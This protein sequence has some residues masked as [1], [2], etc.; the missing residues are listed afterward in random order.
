MKLFLQVFLFA[1]LGSLYTNVLEGKVILFDERVDVQQKTEIQYDVPDGCVV[2]GLGFRAHVDNITTMY[3][4]YHRLMP[5]GTLAQAKEIKL[6]SE[7]E[8]ACEAKIVLPK[9]WVAVGFGAAGEPEWD[10]TLLRI[11]ARKLKPDGTLGEINIFND[12]FKPEREPERHVLIAESNRALTGIG[13]RFNFNDIQ[14]IYARSKGLMNLG[15]DFPEKQKRFTERGWIIEGIGFVPSARL[16]Q[17]L[18]TYNVNRLDIQL[19]F[20]IHHSLNPKDKEWL[21]EVMQYTQLNKIPVYIWLDTIE[22][23]T[24]KEYLIKLPGINGLI[25]NL[26][27]DY[28]SGSPWD[29]IQTLASQHS[30]G[31]LK[32]SF[33]LPPGSDPDVIRFLPEH[34]PLVLPVDYRKGH[35]LQRWITET[36]KLKQRSITFELD[37][38]HR[39]SGLGI[40]PEVR[41]SEIAGCVV[42]AI[43]SGAKGFTIRINSAD[44]YVPDTVNGI[45]IEAVRRLANGPFQSVDKLWSSICKSRYGTASEKAVAALKRTGQINDLIFQ[46]F[47][48]SVLWDTQTISSIPV[49]ERKLHQF[50]ARPVNEVSS[51]DIQA[52]MEPTYKTLERA[53]AEKET[54]QWLIAQSLQEAQELAKNHPSTES[55]ALQKAL[56]QFPQLKSFW[57]DATQAYVL[58]KIYAFDG[59]ESTRADAE[60]SL[61]RLVA[62]AKQIAAQPRTGPLVHG[63]SD[64]LDSIQASLAKSK[65]GSLVQ[66]EFNRVKTYIRQNQH[67]LAAAALAEI[68]IS[69]RLSPY[70]KKQDHIVGE[71]VSQIKLLHSNAN[72]LQVLRGGDG[73]WTLTKIG[74]HWA[75]TI[76]KDAPCIYFNVPGPKLP[77]PATYKVTF[78]YF[79]LGDWRLHFQYDSDYPPEEQRQYHPVTPLQLTNTRTWKQSSFVL[80]KCLFSSAQNLLADMR[81]VT[82]EGAY[83]RNVQIQPHW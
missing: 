33:R 18:D 1:F 73:K 76:G 32:L 30:L 39:A 74:G 57:N 78:E 62:T 15:A 6:G 17:D 45:G 41:L 34:V 42:R 81:F 35:T 40:V 19:P 2:T 60:A 51:L 56:E 77:E 68:L 25:V 82:G 52:L 11:W 16:K 27:P 46:N 3:C 53:K 10:V 72:S 83:I 28:L 22:E 64:Y 20:E 4:R 29:K 59:T 49:A 14:G 71:I 37:L 61:Q 69:P 31:N 79:D 65:T 8:H 24:H 58:A 7:P 21:H 13:L 75:F 70:L 55:R 47:H 48:H 9:G 80:P 50:S 66:Q 38:T 5:D 43:D 26:K 63:L 54:A 23:L 12:G 67:V 36:Q 44:Q